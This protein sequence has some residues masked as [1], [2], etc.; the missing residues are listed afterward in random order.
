MYNEVE[1]F[2]YI[3]FIFSLFFAIKMMQANKKQFFIIRATEY[4]LSFLESALDLDIRVNFEDQIPQNRPVLFVANHFTR[5]ET[6]LVPHILKKYISVMPR[7]LADKGLFASNFLKD[8]LAKA[9]VIST[10]DPKR[11][12]IIVADLVSGDEPWI[13]YPEGKM[14]KDKLATE[15]VDGEER[16]VA[17]T[18]AAVL[19]I[20]AEQKRLNLIK[21]YLKQNPDIKKQ[22]LQNKDYII[23]DGQKVAT[24]S[25][26]IV[27]ISITYTP[28]KPQ[29]N[30]LE[31]NIMKFIKKTSPRLKEEIRMET[32]ILLNST[33]D[34]YFTR[35]IETSDYITSQGVMSALPF[36]NATSRENYAID[37]LRHKVTKAMMKQIYD[38]TLINMEHI[39]ASTIFELL[40]LGK[41][42]IKIQDLSSILLVKC[43][44]LED[45]FTSSHRLD[46]A[47]KKGENIIK[48]EE[49]KSVID[50]AIYQNLLHLD[51]NVI[52]F[53]TNNL[54]AEHQIHAIRTSNILKVFDNEFSYFKN[55]KAKLAKVSST[56]LKHLN[57]AAADILI[58]HDAENFE[59]DYANYAIQGES[60]PKNICKPFLL[61][62]KNGSDE[63]GIV[64]S[65]GYKSAPEEV[66]ELAQHLSNNNINVYCVRLKGHGT[67]ARNMQHINYTDW[68]DSFEAG[69]NI[70]SRVAKKVFV[71]G[72]STGGLASI[73]FTNRLKTQLGA[74]GGICGIVSINSA[75]RIGDIKFKF[76]RV[77]KLGIDLVNK[78]KS[79]EAKI[80]DYVVDKPENPHINYSKNYLHGLSE[81]ALLIE[82]CDKNL[83]NISE[84]ILV[85]QGSNDPV[86]DPVSGDIIFNKVSSMS[87]S[88]YKPQRSRHVIIRGDGSQEVFEKITNFIRSV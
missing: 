58:K 49:F 78:F 38:K 80:H 33:M 27:P 7:S 3:V 39:L 5:A 9:N 48:S 28:I 1:T 82:H 71:G 77:A 47:L 69:Y 15:I 86:V 70:I 43:Q 79:G 63:L 13:I 20:K 66:R 73:A 4:A 21:S 88:L 46:E 74:A 64:L 26:V 83:E 61:R 67:A 87:K 62:A 57:M 40:K 85:I 34:I 44:I 31:T 14:L 24:R 25:L 56:S 75:L 54:L 41:N 81:L 37:K 2:K 84:Q 45:N 12:D 19:A 72:F 35:P 10:G 29:P 55:I 30:S 11:D 36:L 22:D 53:N 8:Y 76:A 23:F 60:K 50:N 59:N 32:S 16:F 42:E 65:H 51:G 6:L 52:K 68:I 18:G 17:K